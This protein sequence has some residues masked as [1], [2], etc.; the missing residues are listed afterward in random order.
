MVSPLTVVPWSEREY[1]LRIRR[2]ES[3]RQP[4]AHMKAI[5]LAFLSLLAF[6]ACNNRDRETGQRAGEGADTMLTTEQTVDTTIVT[7]DTSVDVD[8]THKEGDTPV[9]R[10]TVQR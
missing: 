8:T 10:D 4:G 9:R 1:T 5:S 3:N 7:H 2:H 6:A